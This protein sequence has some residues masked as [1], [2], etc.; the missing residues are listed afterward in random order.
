V[1]LIS[2]PL[3]PP[4]TSSVPAQTPGFLGIPERPRLD[5][6]LSNASMY[7][8]GTTVEDPFAASPAKGRKSAFHLPN[9]F[10]GS[11]YSGPPAPKEDWI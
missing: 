9:R 8:Q 5:S 11:P 7:S 1:P 10:S 3:S 2:L 6:H 4:C